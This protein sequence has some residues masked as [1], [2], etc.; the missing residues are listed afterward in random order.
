MRHTERER[1]GLSYPLLG[2]LLLGALILALFLWDPGL[3]QDIHGFLRHNTPIPLFLAL[4]VLLPLLGFPVSLLFI[5]AGARLGLAWG[6]TAMVLVIP[7]HL[8]SM[9]GIAKLL[10][11]W[12]TRLLKRRNISL[13]SMPETGRATWIIIFSLIPGLS[14]TIKNYVLP[15]AGTRPKE[16]LAIVWPVQVAQ[17]APL[18]LVGGSVSTGSLAPLASGVLLLGALM[19]LLP[20]IIRKLQ[21]LR[22]TNGSESPATAAQAAVA[23]L[24]EF[25]NT[26]RTPYPSSA[27]EETQGGELDD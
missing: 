27:P 26:S 8:A 2:L 20:T 9:F 18:I 25:S 17:S 21:K 12:L 23:N 5:M 7:L 13:P 14:Y 15:L 6:L 3:V 16:T 4:F 24:Q 10:R 11:Q 19:A 1:G 22:R